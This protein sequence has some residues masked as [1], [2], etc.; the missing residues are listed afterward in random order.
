MYVGN[1]IN[2]HETL[3]ISI[4]FLWLNVNFHEICGTIVYILK[5]KIG[6]FNPG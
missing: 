2:A 6:L 1:K 3:S 4:T 5:K